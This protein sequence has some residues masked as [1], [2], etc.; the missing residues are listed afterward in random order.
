[1]FRYSGSKKRLIKYLPEPPF[2][3]KRIVEPFAG[4]LAY[5]MHHR[6]KE[7]FAAEANHLVR[8]LWNWFVEEAEQERLIELDSMR[9]KEKID[10]RTLG[11]SEPETTLLRLQTSGAYVGQLSSWVLYPQHEPGIG[12]MSRN[13]PY[14]KSCLKPLRSDF[15][16]TQ[17]DTNCEDVMVFFDPVYHQTS[18]NYS[19][20]EL[21]DAINPDE[22]S[23]WLL[24]L[25]CPIL[26]TYGE[27]APSRFPSFHWELA[28]ERKVPILRGGGTRDRKE[29]YAKINWPSDYSIL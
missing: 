28:V 27:G 21:G 7:I 1:M 11:L 16:Q 29:W 24:G 26:F 23:E 6:P 4:S 5:S 19:S 2:G 8:G 9:P 12:K 13:L 22:L 25:K 20:E 17:Q 15:R 3:T 18:G 10:A 14:V